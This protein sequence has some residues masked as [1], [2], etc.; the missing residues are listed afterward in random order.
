MDNL[1]N[2]KGDALSV[3]IIVVGNGNVDPN[4]K[5]LDDPVCVSQWKGMNLYVFYTPLLQMGKKKMYR[6]GYLSMVM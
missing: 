2:D 6:M 1:Y 3:M 4:S 5:S